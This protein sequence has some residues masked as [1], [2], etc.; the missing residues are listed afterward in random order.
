MKPIRNTNPR[1][2]SIYVHI[3][4]CKRKCYYCDFVSFDN[5]PND[6]AK[7]VSALCKELESAKQESAGTIFIGGGTP[8][9]L[10]NAQISKIFKHLPK[11]AEV[12]IET[13]PNS[14]TKAKLLHWLSLGINRISIGVQ[15]FDPA[16]LKT[17]GRIHTVKQAIDAIKL[18]HECGFRNINLDII[19]SVTNAPV[20]IPPDIFKY[21]THVSAY[22]LIIE[23]NT[24]FA[25]THLLTPAGQVD[26]NRVISDDESIK[27]Q[28]QIELQLGFN[29]FEKYEVSNFARP[30][31]EC[32]HNLAYWRPQT[33]EYVG[34][35]LGAH[36]YI[37]D[38]RYSNTTDFDKYVSGHFL[39]EKSK[40]ICNLD[41]L[42]VES[43][44]LGLRTTHGVEA[45]L[46]SHKQSELRMLKDLKLVKEDNGRIS[47]TGK[48]F[49]LLNQIIEKLI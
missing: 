1:D 34:F 43:I 13:N 11:A 31:F 3:P 46:L 10:T 47:A 12:T 4:F 37:N 28:K 42:L 40:K 36:S 29:G 27:Q 23:P 24:P 2:F 8:S 35:G 26:P 38:T 22:A 9:I 49:L 20:K 5:R 25:R 15:S 39:E 16:V 21:L 14:V 48:G 33:H 7:Y 6:I 19:H 45:Q 32:K 44:M 30:G 41:D 18:A 17:L